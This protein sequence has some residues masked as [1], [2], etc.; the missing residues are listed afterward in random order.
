VSSR[1]A[2]LTQPGPKRG[3]PLDFPARTGLAS[4]PVGALPALAPARVE[5]MDKAQLKTQGIALGYSIQTALKMVVMYS[6]DH[7]A[8]ARALELAYDGLN[9]LLLAPLPQFTIGFLNHRLVL[10][11]LS[12]DDSSLSGLEAEF[13]RRSLAAI[14]FLSGVTLAEFR[15]AMGVLAIKPKLIEE[16]GGIKNYITEH[17]INRV[18]VLPAKKQEQGDTVLPM[19]TESYFLAENLLMSPGLGGAA[20]LESLLQF[21]KEGGAAG[22]AIS[23][24]KGKEIL[25]MATR[26]TEAAVGDE[27]ADPRTVITQF[28]QLLE[29]VSPERLIG[30]LPPARQEELRGH[31][32]DDVA[33]D[34]AEN[35]TV[36]L[37]MKKLAE[38]PA[39]PTSTEAQET[40][41]RVVRLG[42]NMTRSV[43][44][45]LGK[46]STVLQEANLPPEVYEHI[47]QE[48]QWR[49][50]PLLEKRDHLLALSAFDG[51]G[52]RRLLDY[53][54]E[55]LQERQ[56]EQAVRVATHYFEFL[57]LDS[58]AVEAELPRALEVLRVM[59]DAQVL[60]FFTGTLDRL[61]ADLLNESR[62]PECH[63]RLLDVL[64]SAVQLPAGGEGFPLIYRVGAAMDRSQ[65]RDAFSHAECCGAAL[66]RLLPPE[67][68]EQLIDQYLDVRGDAGL[69]RQQVEVLRWVGKVS[70]EAAF[71]RLAGEQDTATRMRLLRLLAQLGAGAT[72]AA[73]RRLNDE[74]WYVVRNACCVLGET[75]AAD[76][77]KALRGALRHG[78]GRVQQA[79]VAAVARSQAPDAAATLAEVLPD[80]QAEVVEQVLNELQFRK[81]PA[82]IGGLGRFIHLGKGSK[83][84]ALEKAVRALAGIPSERSARVLGVVLWDSGHAPIVRRAAA[85]GLLQSSHPVARRFIEEF[86]RRIPEHPI[87]QAIQKV[88]ARTPPPPA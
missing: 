40:A 12:T 76:A 78:D 9:K 1:Q 87:S 77:P 4:P 53:L 7:P 29:E 71:S 11:D 44:R 34:V 80:L 14:T 79:A 62:A 73:R 69:G 60:P 64:S 46:L 17:P 43:D 49:T 19:D 63:R 2:A 3:F 16:Q 5:S 26:A 10:N 33:S 32:A 24:P 88:L 81:D 20:G 30:A 61:G 38:A 57:G 15:Q 42:L 58:Q 25:E 39:G 13:T 35:V 27:T 84:G 37:V 74:R 67:A 55:C 47:R 36:D 51:E 68:V 28:A 21:A 22:E 52:F 70:G 65:T 48:V 50:L 41:A 85:A 56:A 8:A 82:T 86:V 54:R 83:P 72:D 6:A 18:R 75:G 59:A 45:L 31:P 23:F 66:E